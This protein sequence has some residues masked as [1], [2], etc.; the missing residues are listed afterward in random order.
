MGQPLLLDKFASHEGQ[1]SKNASAAV[2]AKETEEGGGQDQTENGKE[3]SKKVRSQSREAKGMTWE[4]TWKAEPTSA[5]LTKY[6]L[7]LG[8][9]PTLAKAKSCFNV[10]ALASMINPWHI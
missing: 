2:A 5:Q 3:V 9:K 4:P 1:I 10:I 8:V 7:S 6:L